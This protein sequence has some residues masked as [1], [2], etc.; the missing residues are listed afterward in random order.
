MELDRARLPLFAGL[1]VAATFVLLV[2]LNKD[3]SGTSR[4]AGL[5]VITISD[6]KPVGGVKELNYYLGDKMHIRFDSDT[7]TLVNIHPYDVT[8]QLIAGRSLREDL[9]A[10]LATKATIRLVTA[11]EAE[12]NG[13]G[14]VPP[15]GVPVAEITVTPGPSG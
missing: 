8:Y 6:G 11:Q 12:Q 1:L 10:T 9:D 13:A 7:T 4:T 3:N 14:Y 15:Q 2:L 5:Q